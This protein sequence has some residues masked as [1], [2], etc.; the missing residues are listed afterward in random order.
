[1]TGSGR[2]PQLD[3]YRDSR[4]DPLNEYVGTAVVKRSAERTA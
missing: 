4:F 1:M 3:H 2:E